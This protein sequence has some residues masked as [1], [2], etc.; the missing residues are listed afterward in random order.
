MLCTTNAL[1]VASRQF[2]GIPPPPQ[3]YLYQKCARC[4]AREIKGNMPL[5]QYSLYG[6]EGFSDLISHLSARVQPRQARGTWGLGGH[7]VDKKIVFKRCVQAR[8]L[9][10]KCTKLAAC[11]VTDFAG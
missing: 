8:A 9:G 3:S 7:V 4:R 10:T 11:F 1:D 5:V 6:K 2:K